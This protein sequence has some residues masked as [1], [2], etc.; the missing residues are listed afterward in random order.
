MIQY[1]RQIINPAEHLSYQLPEKPFEIFEEDFIKTIMD[2][3][4]YKQGVDVK[5]FNDR[6]L[7]RV[8]YSSDV[9][10]ENDVTTLKLKG[11]N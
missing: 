5:N 9:S 6:L 1:T 7:Q 4:M 8:L 3:E 10:S 2:Y 11:G